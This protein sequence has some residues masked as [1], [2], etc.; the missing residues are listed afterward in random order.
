[1]AEPIEFY[2]DF[3]SPY[4]YIGAHLIDDLAARHGR[5]ADWKPT[6]LGVI[7]K[8][9]GMG[10]LPSY[11][12]KGD[13]ARH[14][15]GR[16]ARYHGVEFNPPENFPFSPVSASRAVYWAKDREPAQAK[17]LALALYQAALRDNRAIG[18]PQEVAE[19]AAE[20]GFDRDEVAAALAE[21]A[22]KQRLADEVD[23]SIAK[24]VFG[25]PHLIVD[26]E[27][28]W[29]VDRFAQV[30]EWLTRGGW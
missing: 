28:F 22:V 2:F 23:A 18:G 29:G 4:G 25:S 9:T 16:S 3:N 6:L 26:G 11:P 14:D 17:A 10:P 21:P 30:E 7:F 8:Q 20:T 27:P 15:F 1:M 5:E 13:Y 19:I 12:I 24:G